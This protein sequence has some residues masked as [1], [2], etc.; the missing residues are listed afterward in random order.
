[1]KQGLHSGEN[2]GLSPLWLPDVDVVR[3]FRELSLPEKSVK[4]HG[5]TPK[6]FVGSFKFLNSASVRNFEI[7]KSG[8]SLPQYAYS[9]WN[10]LLF[11]SSEEK[12][13]ECFHSRGQYL[14][15][16]IGTKESICIRKELNSH[17]TG[18]GHQHGRLF[19]VLW[20]QYGRRDV[21]WKHSITKF[22]R[23]NAVYHEIMRF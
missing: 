1:M 9:C 22:Q 18:L 23:A 8:F 16:F 21:M 4:L 14:C 7:E 20:H 12:T 2:T 6:G 11:L 3:L 5:T 17:R 15:K 10:F 13:I 19:I